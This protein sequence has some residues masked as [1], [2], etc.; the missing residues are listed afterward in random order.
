MTPEDREILERF[1]DRVRSLEPDARVWGFGS[2]VRGDDVEGSDFDI[3]VV[4]PELTPTL[5][6]QIRGIAW[7]LGFE[8]EMVLSTV[9]LSRTD[10]EEGPMSASTLVANVRREGVAA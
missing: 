10:F 7:E 5:R 2:R 3:C 4:V 9:M 8:H 6:E 1:A